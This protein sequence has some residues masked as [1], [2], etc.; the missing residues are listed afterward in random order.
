MPAGAEK[1][2]RRPEISRCL[3]LGNGN[4]QQGSDTV[5]KQHD[6]RTDAEQKRHKHRSAEH[7]EHVL[8]G[9][10]HKQTL[11]FVLDLNDLLD[12]IFLPLPF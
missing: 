4:E 9:Q 2:E 12:C 1:T 5:H 7:G 6:C 11:Y 3:A 10:R 8:N